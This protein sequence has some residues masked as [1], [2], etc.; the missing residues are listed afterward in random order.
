MFFPE[1]SSGEGFPFRFRGP[2]VGPRFV[3]VAGSFSREILM[4]FAL[5]VSGE[6]IRFFEVRKIDLKS[7]VL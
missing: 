2:G 4:V 6:I 1:S 7:G 5:S 3:V